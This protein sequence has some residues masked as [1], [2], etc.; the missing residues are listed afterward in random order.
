MQEHSWKRD[1]AEQLKA[2]DDE[3]DAC[4]ILPGPHPD[5]P[6]DIPPVPILDDWGHQIFACW[7]SFFPLDGHEGYES[8][9]V[10]KAPC[11]F[12][13]MWPAQ[14][15]E[16]I[17]N[18]DIWTRPDTTMGGT[19]NRETAWL[20]SSICLCPYRYGQKAAVQHTC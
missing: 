13:R 15:F 17:M 12:D 4:G 6:A 18:S 3:N 19:L 10:R 1:A 7:R 14:V 16:I 8:S 5:W 20:V 2:L 11:V 9:S